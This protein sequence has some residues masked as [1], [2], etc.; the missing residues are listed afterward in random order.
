MTWHEDLMTH[1]VET[2]DVVTLEPGRSI[3][4][5][6]PEDDDGTDDL[7]V[8]LVSRPGP[9]DETFRRTY[10]RPNLQIVVRSKPD[11]PVGGF[12]LASAVQRSI[13]RIVNETIGT[14]EFVRVQPETTPERLR[15]DSKMRTD[16]IFEVGVWLGGEEDD[17]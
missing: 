7:C 17:I 6:P 4:I 8:G 13:R 3:V 10:N 14:T 5:G 9:V 1:I 12:T 11:D 16:W 15:R 2:V